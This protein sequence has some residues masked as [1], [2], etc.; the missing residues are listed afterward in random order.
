MLKA[1]ARDW[2]EVARKTL[3]NARSIGLASLLGLIVSERSWGRKGP[4]SRNTYKVAIDV[5][6]ASEGLRVLS[7]K[8]LLIFKALTSKEFMMNLSHFMTLTIS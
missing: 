5:N 6:V 1:T 7:K 4:N 3:E 2:R 8:V